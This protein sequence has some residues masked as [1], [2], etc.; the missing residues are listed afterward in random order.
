[1]AEVDI[2]SARWYS[3]KSEN[4]RSCKVTNAFQQTMPPENSIAFDLLILLASPLLTLFGGAFTV[5]GYPVKIVGTAKVHALG[6]M[7]TCSVKVFCLSVCLCMCDTPV[8]T[9]A[10]SF[11]GMEGEHYILKDL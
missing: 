6:R 5:L 9:L 3:N 2:S 8:W 11:L 10:T 7:H 4:H 1:M